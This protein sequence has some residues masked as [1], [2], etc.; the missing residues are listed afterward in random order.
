MKLS[1]AIAL[2]RTMIAPMAG[3]ILSGN[4]AAG[5]AWG[6]AKVAA[7]S[8][9][10]EFQQIAATT[11]VNLPCGCNCFYYDIYSVNALSA[12]AVLLNAIIH[13]FD[14]HVFGKK[15]WTL[16]R[17]I[18]WV[19]ENDIEIPDISPE[20]LWINLQSMALEASKPKAVPEKDLLDKPSPNLKELVQI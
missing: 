11:V 5:C 14:T 6:M 13:L 3:C 19:K 4:G 1:E 2:G 9:Y 17:L 8:L 12:H 15:D 7:P 18:D 16:D 10:A 20:E